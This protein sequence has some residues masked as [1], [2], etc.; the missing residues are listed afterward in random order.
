[1]VTG[2]TFNTI[3]SQSWEVGSHFPVWARV[4]RTYQGGAYIDVSAL[5]LKAGDIIPAGT[6]VKY[7][8][9]GKK[10]E[11][12]TADSI[13]GVKE[14]V[15]VTVT[16]GCTENGNVGITLNGTNTDIAV[17]TAESSANAVAAKIAAGSFTGWTAKQGGASVEFTKEA[18]GECT[19]PS[20]N[21]NETGVTASVEVVT[22]GV[23]AQGSY[24]D[25]NGLVWND[26]MIPE[27]CILAT[28]AVVFGGRIYADRVAGGGLPKDIE[29]NLPMIEFVR[30]GTE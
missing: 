2:R 18:A 27:G 12:F 24:S 16:G 28:C 23:T 26:V 20:V 4:T 14:V 17:T 5:G 15:R 9:P 8:G 22:K 13:A 29:K 19:A 11:V 25:V 21:P 7:T 6:M 3:S 1:M 10:A 30:E